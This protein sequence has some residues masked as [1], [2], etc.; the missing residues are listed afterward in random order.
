MT[1]EPVEPPARV[2]AQPSSQSS[3]EEPAVEHVG[4]LALARLTK[5]DGRALLL[6]S[7]ERDG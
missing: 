5:D 1:A 2:D 6:F 4:P 7:V 3:A